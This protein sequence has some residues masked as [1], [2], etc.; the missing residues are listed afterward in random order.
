MTARRSWVSSK[1]V[2]GH[3]LV[4]TRSS[5]ATSAISD[6]DGGVMVG[7]SPL[8]TILRRPR[9]PA[10]GPSNNKP[11]RIQWQMCSAGFGLM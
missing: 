2:W 6:S 3:V 10:L 5:W 1:L 11:R 7:P 4:A 9:H 8:S